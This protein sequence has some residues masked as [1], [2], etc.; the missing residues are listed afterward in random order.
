MKRLKNIIL[1]VL[2]LVSFVFANTGGGTGGGGVDGGVADEGYKEVFGNAKTVIESG[3]CVY[4]C[5]PVNSNYGTQITNVDIENG[6]TYCKTFLKND[7]T[8]ELK[9]EG[10][11]LNTVCAKEWASKLSSTPRTEQKVNTSST[12]KFENNDHEISFSRFL[13]AMVTLDPLIINREQSKTAGTLV[14]A[15]G[16]TTRGSVSGLYGI[17]TDASDKR[18]ENVINTVS[19]VAG[20]IKNKLT[21]NGLR[22]PL[23]IESGESIKL[24]DAMTQVNFVYFSNLFE[25]MN[26]VYLHLQNLLFV[27]V[28]M[29]FMG[30]IGARKLQ[31]YFENRGASGNK[32]PFLHKFY[33]PLLS[34]GLF[35]MPIP[36]GKNDFE[37]QA[38][39]VQH[40]IRYFTANATKIADVASAKS[41]KVYMDKVYNA[42]GGISNEGEDYY[43]AMKVKNEFIHEQALKILKNNCQKRYPGDAYKKGIAF[44]NMS[45]EEREKAGETDN[46]AMHGKKNDISLTACIKVEMDMYEAKRQI[47]IADRALEGIKKYQKSDYISQFLDKID[48]FSARREYELGWINSSLL[49]GTA[50]V[51]EIGKN[52]GRDDYSEF[53]IQT[54]QQNKETSEKNAQAIKDTQ[55]RGEVSILGASFDITDDVLGWIMGKVIY[56]ILPGYASV[57]NIFAEV[58]ENYP[59]SSTVFAVSVSENPILMGIAGVASIFAYD[60]FKPLMNLIATTWFFDQIFLHL[61]IIVAT[62]ATTIAIVSYLVSLTKYYFISPFVVAFSITTRRMDKIVEFLISGISLFFK[63]VLIVMFVYL[64]LFL[65]VYVKD[66]F[67]LLSNLQFQIIES[68]DIGIV[69][70]IAVSSIQGLLKIF[71]G[72]ASCFIMWKLITGGAEWTMRYIGIDKDNDSTI[73]QSMS[74]HL[75]RKSY[76]G[77]VV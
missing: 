53:L 32:E 16:I 66:F 15:D 13:T 30:G 9:Y 47:A 43:K 73:A 46:S 24:S 54:A 6:R 14:L 61:P 17:R 23:H 5:K 18:Y 49:P 56:G 26:E 34:F 8:A 37:A 40:T 75:E 62:V 69:G 19:D 11:T 28:G 12:I 36:E 48:K 1:S 55:K 52:F 72:M 51:A 41:A 60:T 63:P 20:T 50:M 67:L 71:A 33:V 7:Y 31:S 65:Y 29:F 38:T 10:G 64:S 44:I 74:Q 4:E 39:V 76:G 77:G 45:E 22:T 35:F 42:V 27:V 68:K 2:F 25:A 59:I 3:K 70:M 58:Q 57:K 21:G